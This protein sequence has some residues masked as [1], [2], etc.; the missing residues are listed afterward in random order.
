MKLSIFFT[1]AFL[2]ILGFGQFSTQV[3]EAIRIGESINIDGSLNEIAWKSAPVGTNF[4][5]FDPVPD[6]S[7][8]QKTEVKILYD[9]NAI[10]V[11]AQMFDSE[12]DKILK[13]LSERDNFGNTDWF[14]I[15]LDT[16]QDGLN[17]F[18]FMVTAAGVQRDIRFA[19]GNE[20]SSWD[21]VWES[22]VSLN[23]DGWSVEMRIP[24]SAIRFSNDTQQTWNVQF[25]R[26]IR[27]LR[28][29]VAWNP[30]N[31]AIENFLA[32][33]GQLTGIQEIESPVRLSFTPF[34]VGY[35]NH[36]D[37]DIPGV[38]EWTSAY[39]AG[40]DVKY[41]I[42][43]A[44]TLDMTLIPDFGQTLS[45]QQVLNLTPFEV[46]FEEN[47]QFFTEGIDLFNKA[48]L[49][50]TRRVG[51]RPINY[52]GA[53]FDASP[54]ERVVE[55]PD[56]TN[57]YNASKISGRTSQGTGLGL[58][59]AVASEE[60][61][62]IENI[63]DGSQRSYLTSPL[64]NYNVFVVDQ[65]LPNNSFVSFVNTNVMRDGSFYDANVTGTEFNLRTKNQGYGINGRAALSQKYFSDSNEFGHRYNLFLR[66]L[67][68]NWTYRVGLNVE[69]DDYDHNDLGFLFAPNE[70]SYAA[71][72][73]YTNYDPGGRLNRF[74]YGINFRHERL[75]EPN[76][77]VSSSILF[78]TFYLFKSRLAFGAFVNLDFVESNEYFEP[79]TFDFETLYKFP[80]NLFFN[81]FVSTDYRKPFAL[82]ANLGLRFFD[83][84]DRQNINIG[85]RPRIRFNDQWSVFWNSEYSFD[86]NDEGYVN[87]FLVDN[88]IPE[89]DSDDI[90]FGR[91]NRTRVTNGFSTN[92]IFTST[93]ALTMRVRHY[94]DRVIYQS[95][96][97]LQE[98]GYLRT[99]AYDGRDENGTAIFDQNVNFFN[100]DLNYTWRFAPGSDIIFNWQNQIFTNNK[101]LNDSY[102]QNLNSLFDANQSNSISLRVIYFLDYLYLK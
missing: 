25:I 83:A 4:K 7:P 49:F 1:F 45:D 16:Y 78:N 40:M 30:I 86:K 23:E 53:F 8:S 88:D 92:Y 62:T 47:R 91:R 71:D 12:P 97:P 28:E 57:L 58:F 35:L 44:F 14:T 61:A 68:G 10:Y 89:L 31:P 65:N 70:R 84:Q 34:V 72:L 6:S 19:A 27:R 33:S 17:A 75:F 94:W 9:D 51:G 50:Y 80:R 48:G 42:N 69:S 85:M 56:I 90:L 24:Y 36:A 81:G 99:I 63:I 102:F 43:D 77:F 2:P 21:A 38:D 54:D 76:H 67:S 93:M 96:A 98:D 100:V 32:Q 20:D 37:N 5:Q 55:N 52:F 66:K 79:R 39:N 46:F 41:G 87:R 29:Q 13:Q 95:F 3:L 26:E 101:A 82:D 74:E 18:G 64:T 59:N 73:N 15:I 60:Y 22:D 11:G